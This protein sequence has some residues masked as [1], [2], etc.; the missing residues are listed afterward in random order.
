MISLRSI[1]SPYDGKYL[2]VTRAAA[3]VIRV[4]L[5]LP[6]L[7]EVHVSTLA[8]FI[9]PKTTRPRLIRAFE[10]LSTK[11]DSNPPK[12]HGNIPL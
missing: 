9:E 4:L 11:K 5:L 10:M 2:S 8:P 3:D 7:F 6:I 12:K 1:V